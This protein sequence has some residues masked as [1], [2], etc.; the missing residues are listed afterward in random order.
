MIEA[1]VNGG[2]GVAADFDYDAYNTVEVAARAGRSPSDLLTDFHAARGELIALVE[3][4]TD[5]DLD[6]H[7]RLPALGDVT[8]EAYIKAVY[9]HAKIH[10]R[11]VK[12][13]LA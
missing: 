5:A 2:P 10:V 12:R 3:R 1:V 9:Q 7:G 4:L 8:L 11:D 6:R 13:D